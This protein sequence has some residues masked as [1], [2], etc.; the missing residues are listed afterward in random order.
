MRVLSSHEL[1]LVA[2]GFGSTDDA[3][4][5]RAGAIYEGGGFGSTGGGGGG[6]GGAGGGFWYWVAPASYFTG[7]DGAYAPGGQGGWRWIPSASNG[8]SP[9]G[10]V[11]VVPPVP[12]DSPCEQDAKEDEIAR[13]VEGLIKQQPDWNAREYGALIVRY[14]DGSYGVTA[15]A[16]GETVAE[17]KARAIAAGQTGFSPQLAYKYTSEG[18]AVIVAAIHNHPD[19]DYNRSEDMKNRYPSYDNGSGD[20]GNFDKLIG[21][22]VRLVSSVDQ[23]THYILGPDGVLREFNLKDG[24][25]NP[26]N[27]P[28]PG[29]R[30]NLAADR[31]CG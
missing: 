27:D 3:Q 17:A 6:F 9:G 20:Y 15:L 19:V 11:G 23:F 24:H 28:N 31:P 13:G 4:I 5:N 10:G 22:D 16:R 8:G 7:E 21:R 14:Q 18:G 2:G 12:Q 29:M 25:L 1:D 26:R 30:S